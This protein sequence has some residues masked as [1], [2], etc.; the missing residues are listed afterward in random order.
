MRT[1]RPIAIGVWLAV[2]SGVAPAQDLSANATYDCTWVAPAAHGECRPGSGAIAE[3]VRAAEAYEVGNHFGPSEAT[4]RQMLAAI[5]RARSLLDPVRLSLRERIVTQNAALRIA[6]TVAKYATSPASGLKQTLWREASR[7][8]AWLALEPGQLSTKDADEELDHWLGP[9][10]MWIEERVDGNADA[11]LFHESVYLHTR[12]FRTVRVGDRHFIFSQ[13]VA[14]DTSSRPH[15]TPVIGDIEI[16][17]DTD[18]GQR[19]CI[20]KFDAASAHCGAPAGLRVL[21]RLPIRHLGGYVTVDA[22]GRANCPTCHRRGH[23]F[24]RAILDLAPVDMDGYLTRRRASFLTLL[25]QHLAPIRDAA[26]NSPR[27]D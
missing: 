25:E 13:L 18:A 3:L 5:T 14:I 19:A 12:A 20:A 4:W 1:T 17:S 22:H 16:R 26:V 7:M 15:D 9:R 10:P 11:A 6:R 24:G 23:A 2:H 27:Q 8:I 21:D